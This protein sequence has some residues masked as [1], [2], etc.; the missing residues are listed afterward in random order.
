MLK[1]NILWWMECTY[2]INAF[3]VTFDQFN[4]SFLNKSINSVFKKKILLNQSFK[5]YC[6]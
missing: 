6:F 1:H 2:I 4:V 3:T 5:S